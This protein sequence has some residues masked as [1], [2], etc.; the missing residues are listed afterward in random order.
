[1]RAGEKLERVESKR[2]NPFFYIT[3]VVLVTDRSRAKQDAARVKRI[4]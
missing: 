2:R 4:H 3:T 1:M